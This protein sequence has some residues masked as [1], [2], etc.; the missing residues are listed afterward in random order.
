MNFAGRQVE[1]WEV[2][3]ESG[4]AALEDESIIEEMSFGQSCSSRSGLLLIYFR[5][6]FHRWL[7][8]EMDHETSR[9]PPD[10]T[11]VRRQDPGHP[12]KLWETHSSSEEGSFTIPGQGESTHGEKEYLR[13][14]CANSKYP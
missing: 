4:A 13:E 14:P 5:V 11:H 2:L 1:S 7:Q 12:I 3:P 10:L 9:A 6:P 8:D